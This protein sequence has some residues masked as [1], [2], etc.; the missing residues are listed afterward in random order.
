MNITGANALKNDTYIDDVLRS[1][2]SFDQTQKTATEITE[3]LSIGSMQ[4]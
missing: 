4:I 3:V 2:D 1:E